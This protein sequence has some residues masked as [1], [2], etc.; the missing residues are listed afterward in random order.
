MLLQR[1]GP[2]MLQT[3]ILRLIEKSEPV[4]RA[5]LRPA[6]QISLR[7][8]LDEDSCASPSPLFGLPH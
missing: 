6:A 3:D 2:M 8:S 1:W 4:V 5:R 7:V